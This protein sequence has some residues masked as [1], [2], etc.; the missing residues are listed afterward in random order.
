MTALTAYRGSGIAELLA[1][2][3]LCVQFTTVGERRGVMK[4][5]LIYVSMAAVGAAAL[6]CPVESAA[7]VVN[8]AE[9]YLGDRL[10]ITVDAKVK[11]SDRLSDGCLVGG[12]TMKS[13][14]TMPNDTSTL[15]VL[16]EKGS[17]RT[18]CDG[19]TPVTNTKP[20]YAS[21]A[22]L[23]ASGLARTGVTYGALVV[24]FKYQLKGDNDFTGSATLGGY[25]GYRF[26]TIRQIGLTATPIVFLGAS[27]I[28]V[29]E[30]DD[31]AKNV[32]GAS[33]GFGIIST[34]KGA[35]QIGA[36]LG[37]DRVGKSAGY[38]YNGKPW[39]AIE[40][41]FAFLQ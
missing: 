25:V 10:R 15:A 41:G 23:K 3:D 38:E 6:W 14:G 21:I 24:P 9:N 20:Y 29:N 26:E 34:L 13:F 35:F 28:S 16:V 11:R 30:A 17:S 32:M 33:F 27:N 40:I 22:E 12:T 18:E 5:N 8:D 2:L 31:A 4:G 19:T 36:V 1:L 7:Q 37:W 39:L